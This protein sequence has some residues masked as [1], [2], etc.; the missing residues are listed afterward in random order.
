MKNV[1]IYPNP[2]SDILYIEGKDIAIL[3]VYDIT[4]KLNI[5]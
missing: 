5:N 4:G 2:S 3:K 1:C